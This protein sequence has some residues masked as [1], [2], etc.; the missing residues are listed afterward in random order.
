ME[1]PQFFIWKVWDFI[2]LNGYAVCF[3]IAVVLAWVR[4]G[5]II[6]ELKQLN[7]QVLKVGRMVRELEDLNGRTAFRLK[8]LHI[9]E[10]GLEKPLVAPSDSPLRASPPTAATKINGALDGRRPAEGKGGL[11][12]AR[13]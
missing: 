7:G 4:L 13:L 8:R 5:R 9:L 1:L 12:Q 2:G 6:H 3:G 11:R 10:Q